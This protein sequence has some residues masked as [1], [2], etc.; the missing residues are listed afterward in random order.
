MRPRCVTLCLW[1]AVQPGA[2]GDRAL[3]ALVAAAGLHGPLPPVSLTL[4]TLLGTA[5]WLRSLSGRCGSHLRCLSLQLACS[6]GNGTG[7]DALSA[8]G[9][10]MGDEAILPR[11][12]ALVL[13]VSAFGL[14]D[15]GLAR[16]LTPLLHRNAWERL[17]LH[18]GGNYVGRHATRALMLLGARPT[19]QWGLFAAGAD[20]APPVPWTWLFV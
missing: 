16:C 18:V 11:L 20:L 14:T 10:L 9:R 4:R 1:N 12:C 6:H 19:V 5:Q 3:D 15:A 2:A 17:V 8:V 13:D 7:A